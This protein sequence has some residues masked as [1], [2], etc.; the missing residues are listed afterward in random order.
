MPPP[1]D[2]PLQPVMKVRVSEPACL[3]ELVGDL[4]EGGC[5]PATVDDETVEVAHPLA[6]DAKEARIE[7][8]F[9]LRAWQSAHPHVEV[10]FS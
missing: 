2:N 8:A 5:V 6:R 4:V 7:L 3:P 10:T 9:F 1:A